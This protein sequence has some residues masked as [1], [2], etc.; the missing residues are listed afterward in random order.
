MTIAA[1]PTARWMRAIVEGV[2]VIELL[3]DRASVASRRGR[4]A[5]RDARAVAVKAGNML[6][7]DAVDAPEADGVDEVKVRTA[8]ELRNLLRPVR[9]EKAAATWAAAAW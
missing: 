2:E 6:D 8:P 5:S 4:A 9:Q 7:E 1:P 3:R